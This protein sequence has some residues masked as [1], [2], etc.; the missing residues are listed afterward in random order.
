MVGETGG[1]EKGAERGG[2]C[3]P[4]GQRGS[5]NVWRTSLISCKKYAG[6]VYSK[7]GAADDKERRNGVGVGM[8]RYVGK[9]YAS[10]C[11]RSGR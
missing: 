7:E 8:V 4:M 6:G 10:E 9:G 5:I 11:A 1:V 3:A 2:R